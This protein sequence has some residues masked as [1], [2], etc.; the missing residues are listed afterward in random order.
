MPEGRR[1]AWTVAVPDGGRTLGEGTAAA[2]AHGLVTLEQIP[3]RKGRNR[4]IIRP[5]K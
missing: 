2:D 4:V 5:V 1:F 3:L